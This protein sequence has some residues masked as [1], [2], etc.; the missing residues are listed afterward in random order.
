MVFNSSF[1]DISALMWWSILL[2]EGGT[3]VPKENHRPAS[4]HWFPYL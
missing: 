4:S 2:V 1:N 3:T